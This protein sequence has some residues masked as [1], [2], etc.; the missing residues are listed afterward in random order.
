MYKINMYADQGFEATHVLSG[1]MSTTFLPTCTCMYIYSS[2]VS[3]TC[4]RL[5]C[6]ALVYTRNQIL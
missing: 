4:D 5:M 1:C 3:F 2:S 6:L